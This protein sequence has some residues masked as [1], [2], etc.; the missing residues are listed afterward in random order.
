MLISFFAS[1]LKFK[2]QMAH[3][4]LLNIF[5]EKR[6]KKKQ[7]GYLNGCFHLLI[8]LFPFAMCISFHSY[9]PSLFILYPIYVGAFDPA[10]CII[11]FVVALNY[12][13][14]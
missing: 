12:L 13:L 14:N 4:F 6:E 1:E 11:C 10:S 2:T 9:Y 7:K 5:D 3:L 8:L